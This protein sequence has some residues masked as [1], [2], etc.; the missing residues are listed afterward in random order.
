MRGVIAGWGGESARLPMQVG[1][2]HVLTIQE[3][4]LIL[5]AL[6]ALS[7]GVESEGGEAC[8]TLKRLA[9]FEKEGCGR[10]ILNLQEVQEQHDGSPGN[11]RNVGASLVGGVLVITCQ[12]TTREIHQIKGLT[13]RHS[14]PG[15]LISKLDTLF[16]RAVPGVKAAIS[17]ISTFTRRTKANLDRIH[18]R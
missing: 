13:R 3:P 7:T 8:G 6:N 15:H 9:E 12:V 2:K 11:I 14:F 17:R 16:S 4:P 1:E 10:L 18:A 5:K